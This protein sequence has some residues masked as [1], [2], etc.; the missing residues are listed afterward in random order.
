M[1]YNALAGLKPE[2]WAGQLLSRLRNALVFRNVVNMDYEGEISGFG[3]VVKINEI[4]PITV[5]SYNSTSTGSLTVQSLSD[6]QK[7]LQ[8]NQAKYFAFWIDDV[9]TAQ[10]KPKVM[11]EAMQESAHAMGSNIDQY[12]AAM[13]T[14]AGLTVGGTSSTG[15]DITSTNVLKYLSIAQQKLDENNVPESGRWMVVPPW[16][17]H[18]LVLNRIVQDTSNSAVLA[19]GLLGRGLYGFDIYKSN[20]VVN[21]TGTGQNSRIL[22]G[23]RGSISL[24]VQV[25]KLETARPSLSGGFK[26]LVKGLVVYGAKVVRPATLGVLH[27]DYVAEAT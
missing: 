2:V 17:A 4:G 16:F 21:G 15:Q 19:S 22:C 7:L 27:A 20:N 11:D 23:Y 13:W 25:T 1:A 8:I 18:K 6:A 14:E 12:I 5:N 26:T 9:D 3:D 10:I 24:A